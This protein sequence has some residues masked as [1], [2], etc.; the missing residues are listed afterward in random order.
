MR[1]RLGLGGGASLR[2]SLPEPPTC[3][4]L[5]GRGPLGEDG[6]CLAQAWT[7][8]SQSAFRASL[9]DLDSSPGRQA[10]RAMS[11]LAPQ[12]RKGKLTQAGGGRPRLEPA[13]INPRGPVG[14]LDL[15]PLPRET[16]T[17]SRSFALP[18]LGLSRSS[19]G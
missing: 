10:Q 1:F 8:L 17:P 6:S 9:F 13:V 14:A 15:E 4:L 7:Y 5:P 18:A 12:T 2:Y 19:C 16:S 3:L 11:F